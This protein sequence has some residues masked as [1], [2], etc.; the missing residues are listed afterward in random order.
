MTTIFLIYGTITLEL[1]VIAL[2][3][4]VNRKLHKRRFS[5]ISFCVIASILALSY[6]L[7][8][9]ELFFL[10]TKFLQIIIDSCLMV[11]LAFYFIRQMLENIKDKKS[12]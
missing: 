8:G 4:F 10:D 11:G 2:Y 1:L 3:F 9:L 12:C 6:F 7:Y 5:D